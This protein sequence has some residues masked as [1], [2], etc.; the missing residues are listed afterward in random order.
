MRFEGAATEAAKMALVEAAAEARSVVV[1]LVEAV[2]EARIHV[3]TKVWWSK[4]S[5]L[6]T[7]VH[8]TRR[9][10]PPMGSLAGGINRPRQKMQW[11]RPGRIS[12]C[13]M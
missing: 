3:R 8:G 13:K 1:E 4:Q 12:M 6:E 7:W 5:H 2:E 11:S 10:E 9:G